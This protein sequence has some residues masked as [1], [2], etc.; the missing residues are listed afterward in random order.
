MNEFEREPEPEDQ[1]L[2]SN[3]DSHL[4]VEPPDQ[5]TEPCYRFFR[6]HRELF[7][8]VGFISW[9]AA[10]ADETA[11]IAAQ[12]LY[13]TSHNEEEKVR[14]QEALNSEAG[15]LATMRGHGQLVLQMVVAR[16]ADNFLAYVSELLALVFTVRPEALKSND[17][18]RVDFVL[19][20]E[21]LEELVSSLAE[22]RV[23]NLS[24]QSPRDLAAHL[25]ERLGLN[26]FRDA[27]DM[28]R[29][30]TILESRNLIVHNRAVVN[31]LYL[32]RVRG[33][34]LSEGDRLKFD[35]DGVFGDAEF[36]ADRV[37]EIDSAAGKFGLPK[38][39]HRATA[40]WR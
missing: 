20:H 33:C 15:A 24:Y 37:S 26:L 17:Q 40:A 38:P 5:M 30:V 3:H 1:A 9:L 10:H 29:A 6:D 32:S 34:T 35:V 13:E 16:S 12:A 14:Y 27:D 7:S 19:G 31:R 11:R 28:E 8:F 4:H 22:R 25:S 18:V 21:S 23:N 36:L 2:V 39:I